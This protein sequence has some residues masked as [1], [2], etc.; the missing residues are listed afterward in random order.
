[1]TEQKVRAEVSNVLHM[2]AALNKTELEIPLGA[3]VD[4][5]ELTVAQA[6]TT[7]PATS[8]RASGAVVHPHHARRRGEQITQT[9]WR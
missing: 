1:M 3:T 7:D 6:A 2:V 4:Y 8:V 5:G 9:T